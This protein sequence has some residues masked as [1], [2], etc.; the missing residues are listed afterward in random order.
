VIPDVERVPATDGGAPR[1]NVTL[2][3]S[4]QQPFYIRDIAFAGN[5]NTHEAVIRERLWIV[6]GDVYNEERVIQSY[7]SI[8]GL[9]L[10][11]G[12]DADAATSSRARSWGW[13]TS[14][15]T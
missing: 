10:L 6:P 12:A 15:S 5:T 13:W 7:Q 3:V 11:R 1:V 14:S 8:A 2:A 4:E 9:G